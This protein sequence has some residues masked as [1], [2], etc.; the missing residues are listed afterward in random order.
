M[1]RL[2]GLLLFVALT[3]QAQILRLLPGNI[4]VGEVKAISAGS[5]TIDKK[6][7]PLALTSRVFSTM[8]STLLPSQLPAGGPVA[9]ML[10]DDG[11]IKTL[12]F[13]TPEEQQL[14]LPKK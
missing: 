5:L 8:N 10:N 4:S 14:L 6:S 1:K 12:W 9:F 11:S 7:Y 2:T 13:L 3:A